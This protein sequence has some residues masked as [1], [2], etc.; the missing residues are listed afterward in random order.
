MHNLLHLFGGASILF[1]SKSGK[2]L[3]MLYNDDNTRVHRLR[4]ASLWWGLLWSQPAVP[5]WEGWRKDVREESLG[6]F[7]LICSDIVAKNQ[8]SEIKTSNNPVKKTTACPLAGGSRWLI[9][10]IQNWCKSPIVLVQNKLAYYP[11]FLGFLF[12]FILRISPKHLRWE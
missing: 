10:I 4:G 7:L 8:D 1:I 12:F 3:T 2:R 11:R 6:I 9:C 5:P